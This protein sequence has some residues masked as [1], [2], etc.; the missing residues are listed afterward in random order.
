MTTPEPTPDVPA[1]CRTD[2]WEERVNGA[3]ERVACSYCGAPGQRVS[4]RCEYCQV[5]V[6]REATR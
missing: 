2:Y 3:P 4:T 5:F 6:S 1:M